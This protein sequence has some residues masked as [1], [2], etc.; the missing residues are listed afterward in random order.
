MTLDSADFLEP[1][2]VPWLVS[3]AAMY[4]YLREEGGLTASGARVR[5]HSASGAT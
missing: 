3:L 5:N 1:P 2:P 4:L